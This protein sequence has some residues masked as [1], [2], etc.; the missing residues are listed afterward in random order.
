MHKKIKNFP[1]C[2]V[3]LSLETNL[4]KD[5]LCKFNKKGILTVSLKYKEFL[6][7]KKNDSKLIFCR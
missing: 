1:W 7:Y 4:L 3:D 6:R 2:E 5:E